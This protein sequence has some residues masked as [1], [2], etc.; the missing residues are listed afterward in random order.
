MQVKGEMNYRID[1]VFSGWW[2]VVAG[3]AF[4]QENIYLRSS[5]LAHVKFPLK[6]NHTNALYI[7]EH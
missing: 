4:P 7:W 6:E 2:K 3:A 5:E 1:S